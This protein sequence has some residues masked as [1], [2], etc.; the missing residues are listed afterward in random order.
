MMT[1][2]LF[3]WLTLIS[4][5]YNSRG[6]YVAKN[7]EDKWTAQ[8]WLDFVWDNSGFTTKYTYVR[9]TV[10]VRTSQQFSVLSL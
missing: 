2:Y 7:E 9:Y 1:L 10:N 4:R 5:Q 3:Y 6:Q 8:L